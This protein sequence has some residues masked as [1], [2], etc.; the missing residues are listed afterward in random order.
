MRA[1]N[2]RWDSKNKRRGGRDCAGGPARSCRRCELQAVT[3]ELR[4]CACGLRA[5][6][7]GQFRP[8]SFAAHGAILNAPPTPGLRACARFLVVGHRQPLS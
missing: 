5:A 8:L 1:S 3:Q 2:I 6:G 7:F 4:L